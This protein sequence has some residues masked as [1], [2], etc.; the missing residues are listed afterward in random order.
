MDPI[1]NLNEQRRIAREILKIWDGADEHGCLESEKEEQ[2]AELAQ[3]LA[4]L[5]LALDEW[6]LKGG[7]SPYQGAAR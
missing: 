1:A 2:A 3:R 5:V 7:F 6:Q 4:E